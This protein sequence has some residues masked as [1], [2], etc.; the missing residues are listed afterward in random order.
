[1]GQQQDQYPDLQGSRRAM[2]RAARRAAEI[3]RQHNQ[4]LVFWRDGRIVRVMPDDL[5]PLPEVAPRKGER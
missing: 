4:P 1:M 2:I 3:A 5:P